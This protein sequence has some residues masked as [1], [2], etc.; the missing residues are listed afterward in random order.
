MWDIKYQISI[1]SGSIIKNY[2]KSDH[3]LTNRDNTTVGE[4]EQMYMQIT[5]RPDLVS[6]LL[7]AY[8]TST[9]DRQ[10]LVE[11]L[12]TAKDPMNIRIPEQTGKPITRQMLDNYLA[13][14]EIALKD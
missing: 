7:R 4:M 13:V 9:E 3:E 8:S 12:V 2:T 14:L 6:K 1:I 5:K 11:L 10:N